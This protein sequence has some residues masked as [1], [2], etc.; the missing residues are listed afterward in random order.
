MYEKIIDGIVHCPYLNVDRVEELYTE[1]DGVPVTYVC[2]SA[3][4]SG[5][6]PGDIFYR[7]TPHP[8]FGNK[9]FIL[10]GPSLEH[11]LMI[12]DA[13]RIESYEFSMI[14]SSKGW[15]YSS[16]R[17]DYKSTDSGV[18]DGGRAYTRGWGSSM[19]TLKD[20]KFTIHS[21]CSL[22]V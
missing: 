20:G 15:L 5:L 8:E 9:Y 19:F 13:D 3:L 7:A 11:V 21:G 6:I 16:H 17:H 4:D 14:P 2:T 1:K 10:Y 12:G 18:I 22:P